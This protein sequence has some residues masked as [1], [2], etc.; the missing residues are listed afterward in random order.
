MNYFCDHRKLSTTLYNCERIRLL[1]LFVNALTTNIFCVTSCATAIC[2]SCKT[3][4]S[5][6]SCVVYRTHLL[7]IKRSVVT[8]KLLH[9]CHLGN[10][11]SLSFVLKL[12]INVHIYIYDIA[13]CVA[14]VRLFVKSLIK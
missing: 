12:A 4:P 6:Q 2:G 14:V 10:V 5:M 1:Q 8:D 13:C 11:S 7:I 3:I 9:L